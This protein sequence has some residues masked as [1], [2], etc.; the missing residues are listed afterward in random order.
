MA[1]LPL[2]S[3]LPGPGFCLTSQDN[4]YNEFMASSSRQN[5]GSR[6]S[7]DGIN[8][9][10]F[11]ELIEN[12]LRELRNRVRRAEVSARRRRF[13]PVFAAF[14]VGVV[15]VFFVLNLV[16]TGLPAGKRILGV[17]TDGLAGLEERNITSSAADLE[18]VV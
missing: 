14:A 13:S 7:L 16:G 5:L 4:G 18:S 6:H 12:R 8:L 15:A 9:V 10:H 17:A 1:G 11:R 3:R 2:S